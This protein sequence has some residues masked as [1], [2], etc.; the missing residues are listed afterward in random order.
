MHVMNN[1]LPSK[2]FIIVAKYT[3]KNLQADVEETLPLD[4]V[5][6]ATLGC[7]YCTMPPL[8]DAKKIIGMKNAKNNHQ[9]TI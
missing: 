6:T 9:F 7:S 2:D 8:L 1:K 4:T 3:E 5:Q